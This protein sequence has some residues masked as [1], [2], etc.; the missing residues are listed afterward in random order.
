MNPP[1]ARD[2]F[3]GIVICLF[4]NQFKVMLIRFKIY[5]ERVRNMYGKNSKYIRKEYTTDPYRMKTRKETVEI[6]PC[7]ISTHVPGG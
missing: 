2:G 3:P 7:F 1:G 5:T 6:S 4:L